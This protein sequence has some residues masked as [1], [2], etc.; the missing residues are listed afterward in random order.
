MNTIHI[1]RIKQE[2]LLKL[3]VLYEEL[4]EEP[5]DLTQLE[6]QFMIMDQ[7]PHYFL[8]GAKDNDDLAGSVMGVICRDLIGDGRPFMVIEN[9]IVSKH[10]HRK[11][12]GQLLMNELER[13][14]NEHRC[15]YMI[16]VSSGH[17]TA[18]HRFYENLGYTED[19]RGF[20]KMLK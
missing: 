15:G 16:L 2:D 19:V 14:A 7:D 20:R 8:L 17:R 11:G 6:G 3:K 18:A 5:T 12:V 10:H 9:V 13:I 1:S 4:I